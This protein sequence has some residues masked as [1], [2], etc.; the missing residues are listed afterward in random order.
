MAEPID[1]RAFPGD[2]VQFHPSQCRNL[3]FAACLMTVTAVKPWGV[4]GFVQALGEGVGEK[5]KQGGQYYYRAVWQEIVP[6]G[7]KAVFVL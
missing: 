2:I 3:C 6:T 4:I 1:F 7:G 5:A